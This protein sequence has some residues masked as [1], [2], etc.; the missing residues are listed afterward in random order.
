MFCG[1]CGNSVSVNAR[2]CEYCGTEI[3]Q[4]NV[5]T[6]KMDEVRKNKYVTHAKV[7]YPLNI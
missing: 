3:K 5:D 1:N 4:D 2:F 6:K 7:M